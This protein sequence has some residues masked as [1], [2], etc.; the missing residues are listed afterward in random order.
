MLVFQTH[1]LSIAICMLDTIINKI[2]YTN[3]NNR[4][5][6]KSFVQFLVIKANGSLRVLV[7]QL[8]G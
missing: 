8:L 7:V 6:V 1:S 4:T 2:N 3:A 5:N